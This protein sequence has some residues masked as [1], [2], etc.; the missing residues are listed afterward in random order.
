MQTLQ[1]PGHFKPADVVMARQI[2][3][4]TPLVLS[5]PA[6]KKRPQFLHL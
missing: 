6:K 1:K 3:D 2:A 5:R 4:E